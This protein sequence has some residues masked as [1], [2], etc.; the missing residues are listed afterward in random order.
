MRG[1]GDASAALERRGDLAEAGER[2]RVDERLPA[3]EGR[4]EH[5]LGDAELAGQAAHGDG[6]PPV[7]LGDLAGGAHDLVASDVQVR[8]GSR[9]HERKLASLDNIDS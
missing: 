7:G 1:M 4:V 9:T 3:R 2:H 5:R 8:G 6:G